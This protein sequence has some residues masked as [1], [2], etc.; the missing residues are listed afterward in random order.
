MIN[1]N[2]S[3]MEFTFEK[4]SY[5]S[6]EEDIFYS[7]LTSKYGVKISDFIVLKNN[8]L[9]FI[10]AKSSAP[11]NVE[12][13][14]SFCEDIYNKFLDTI[15]VYVGVLN[16][17]KN[18]ISNNIT[19]NMKNINVL[20]KEIKLMLIINGLEKKYLQDI[21]LVL[22]KSLRKLKYMFSIQSLILM[23]DIQAKSKG[24]IK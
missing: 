19:N 21:Q 14:K 22:E 23:N 16:N 7:K 9:I 3:N 18:T 12:D 10:E 15:L 6:V 8:T 24:F 17:R 13:L 11:K 5:Y 1:R 4:N 20:K 2:E